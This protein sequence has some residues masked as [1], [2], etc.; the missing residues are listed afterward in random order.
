[1][2]NVIYDLCARPSYVGSLRAEW[3]EIIMSKHN[4]I[5]EKSLS[6]LYKMDSFMRE[7][8]RLTPFTVLTL[9]RDINAD[10]ILSNGQVL[11]KG[12]SVGA[13]LYAMNR[14]P[15]IF[16][17]PDVFDGERFVKLRARTEEERAAPNEKPEPRWGAIDM[18]PE[19][20][21]N[22]GFG[23]HAC[24]GRV[25]AVNGVCAFHIPVHKY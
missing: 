20:N 17:D 7:S 18:H 12:C 23:K 9:N 22:F 1:M 2:T 21:I 15:R 3:E 4:S 11:P 14:D 16:Q 24:P 19:A 10:V 25:L 8:Q 13:A 5:T 6:H